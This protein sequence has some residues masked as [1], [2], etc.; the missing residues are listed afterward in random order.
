[1]TGGTGTDSFFNPTGDMTIAF[2]A[3]TGN[4]G[5]ISGFDVITDFTLAN[6]TAVS[7]SL[8]VNASGTTTSI[9]ANTKTS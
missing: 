6:G 3:G 7:E 9:P 8:R 4:G 2:G 5:S 1:M